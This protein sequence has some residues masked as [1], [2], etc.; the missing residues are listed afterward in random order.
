MRKALSYL[1]DM[2]ALLILLIVFT[3]ITFFGPTIAW[4]FIF[5]IVTFVVVLAFY[6]RLIRFFEVTE[7]G[8]A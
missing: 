6:F 8:E 1:I 3:S 5:L 2:I 7:K 4:R